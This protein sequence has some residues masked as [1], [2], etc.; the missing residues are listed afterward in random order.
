M[1]SLR[2]ARIRSAVLWS[3]LLLLGLAPP[4]GAAILSFTGTLGFGVAT[5]PQA[6]ISGSGVATVNGS[7]GGV[8]LSSL[9]IPAGVFVGSAS[10]VVYNAAPVSGHLLT[11]S[12]SNGGGSFA[13]LSNSANN[14][15]G[16]MAL[17]GVGIV[18][19]FD[20][21]SGFPGAN[22]IVPLSVVGQGGTATA[23]GLINITAIGAPWLKNTASV[24]IGATVITIMGFAHGPASATQSTT[25]QPS[26]VL[27]L[28]TPIFLST[29]VDGFPIVAT[30][31]RMTLHFV[32]EPSTLLLVS[33]GVFG[34]VIVGRRQTRK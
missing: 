20:A 8:H 5:L 13:G 18:C 16:V 11:G 21:C 19:L 17:S 32:P 22:L 31:S 30:F 24:S 28:V 15:V 4:A 27:S 25:A 10:V 3:S 33:L 14:T 23:T 7:G 29:S 1:C 6:Q 9:T 12:V 34:F 2:L 26:G